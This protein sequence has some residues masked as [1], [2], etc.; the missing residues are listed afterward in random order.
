VTRLAFATVGLASL[1][2]AFAC[3]DVVDPCGEASGACVAVRVDSDTA[4]E[5]DQ[6]ELDV[7][8]GT[9]HATTSTQADG[10]RA[11]SLPVVTAIEVD[12]AELELEPGEPLSVGVVAAGKLGG[13]LQGVGAGSATVPAGGRADIDI[14]LAPPQEC[15]PGGHYCGGD[16]LAGDPNTLYTCI[17]DSVPQAR[18]VCTAGCQVQAADDDVCR[19]DGG[20]CVEG[21][22][23][24]GGD[25]L[26]GDPATLYTCASGAGVNGQLCPNGCLVRPGKDDVCR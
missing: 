16:Q 7:L 24:C 10:G 6:L 17:E 9:R 14:T 15:T 11:V 21:G 26:V 22:F 2:A 13:L 12:L 3:G 23:Y 1:L 20:R 5:I 25:K 18:G 19:A 4:D 8:Y